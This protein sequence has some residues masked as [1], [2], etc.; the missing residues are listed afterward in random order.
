MPLSYADAQPLLAALGGQTVPENWRGALPLT[1]RFG[2][3]EAQLHLKITYD[4]SFA[5]IYDVIATLRGSTWP[6]E[7][8]I[9]GNHRDGWVYGAQDPHSAHSAFLEE[10]RALGELHKDGWQPKRTIIYA[11]W[12]AEEQGTIGS[13]EWMEAHISDLASKG[14]A[15]LNTDVIGPGTVRLTGAASLAQFVSSVASQISDPQSGISILDRARIK[16]EA[17]SP[18]GSASGA[19]FGE[20]QRGIR[21]GAL[22]LAHGPPRLRLRSPLVRELRWHP[23]AEP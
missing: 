20:L 23:V 1:Y 7:W 12:D 17:E 15:Y 21:R 11:S 8:V 5:E 4:W 14:V 18:S 22:A 9:R 10:A 6:D 13:T 2:P 16:S 3:S 19:S